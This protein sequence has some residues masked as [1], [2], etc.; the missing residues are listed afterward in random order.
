MS[1]KVLSILKWAALSVMLVLICVLAATFFY[2]R[3]QGMFRAPV[4]D[5]VPPSDVIVGSPAI[6][7]FTKTNGFVHK[8]AIPAAIKA[9]RNIAE[10]KGWKLY[11]TNNGAIHNSEDLQKF[12]ALIWNNVSG[13]VL[14]SEQREALK[15]YLRTGGGFVGLHA[16]GGDP[17]YDWTWYVEDVI[18]AQFIGRPLFPQKQQA[19]L[20]VEE[21]ADPI[22]AHLP[23][24]WRMSDEW[25]S[26]AQSPRSQEGVEVLLSI[27]ETSYSPSMAGKDIAMGTDHPLVWKHCL[28]QGRVLYSALGHY[29]EVYR[30]KNYRILLKNAVSWAANSSKEP[31]SEADGD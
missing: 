9:V 21:P 27:S 12:D 31:C 4:Y 1:F 19:D 22:V 29:P 14:T 23:R 3:S 15:Q 2:L 20:W 5:H 7:L 26:F 8:D 6:L 30:N 11:E 13:D 28:G 16:S 18:R 24:P 25:Y 10:E 17:S